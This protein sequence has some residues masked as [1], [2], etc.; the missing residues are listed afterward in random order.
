MIASH[1]CCTSFALSLARAHTHHYWERETGRGISSHKLYK[2]LTRARRSGTLDAVWV[3]VCT[4]FI[5]CV[6]GVWRLFSS[7]F[8]GLWSREV[9]VLWA[10]LVPPRLDRLQQVYSSFTRQYASVLLSTAVWT[11]LVAA[12]FSVTLY[13][14]QKQPNKREMFAC[15]KV[16]TLIGWQRLCCLLSFLLT[17]CISSFKHC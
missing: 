2:R 8:Y 6:F 7:G 17:V 12:L 13:L 14:V 4:G 15:F 11:R 3:S 1:A 5:R 16:Q 9:W 10:A